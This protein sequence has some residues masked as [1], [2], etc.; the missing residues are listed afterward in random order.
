MQSAALVMFVLDERAWISYRVK[1]LTVWVRT[2]M[3]Q[4]ADL[5]V[6]PFTVTFVNEEGESSQQLIEATD[7]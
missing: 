5:I 3:M 7:M 6:H 2:H 1:P 4:M